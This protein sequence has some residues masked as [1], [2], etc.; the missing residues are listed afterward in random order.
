MTQYLRPKCFLLG[1]AL[2]FTICC[3]AG[4]FVSTKARLHHFSRFFYSIEPQMFY[5]PTAS[6][7]LVTARHEVNQNQIL[8]LLGGSSIF[9]G[10]GQNPD[11]LWS[12][13]L[14]RQLGDKFKVLNY[15]TD[16]ASFSS[17]GGAVF[18][19][20][21]KEYPKIIF[22]AAAY[23]FNSEGGMDG[24]DPYRYFFWDAYYKKLFQPDKKEA[25]II[26]RMQKEQIRTVKG[27]EE[28]ILSVLDSRFYFRNLWNWVSYRLMFTAWSDYAW[29]RPF[30]A[31]RTYHDQPTPKEYMKVLVDLQHNPETIKKQTDFI[32]QIVTNVL[33]NPLKSPLQIAEPVISGGYQGYDEVYQPEDRSKILMVQTT[34]NTNI[35]ASLPKRYQKGYWFITSESHKMIESLG[36]HV[37]DIGKKFSPDDYIDLSHFQASGGKKLAIEVAKKVREIAKHNNY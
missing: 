22:V 12:D 20:L 14:Q 7:L 34:Y 33:V 16:A 4:Y 6:E 28:H 1:I 15:A 5:Y 29:K 24:L 19:M 13:E 31:R 8:V 21:R 9:R 27:A 3:L 35:I 36:Y 2:G 23:Q 11:E 17:F 37:L 10:V 26:K 18:R 30:R 25:A 32:K